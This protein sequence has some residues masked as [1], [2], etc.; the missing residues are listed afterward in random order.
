MQDG[1]E[2]FTWWENGVCHGSGC[3]VVPSP[4]PPPFP[5]PAPLAPPPPPT[6]PPPPYVP[7][8]YRGTCADVPDQNG[9]TVS[10][11]SIVPDGT[12]HLVAVAGCDTGYAYFC[13]DSQRWD[14]T[15][16]SLP[17]PP[18]C[19]ATRVNADYECDDPSQKP[20]VCLSD[21]ANRRSS[22]TCL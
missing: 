13:G 19:T 11:L 6:P 20:I 10:Y 3:P 8:Y 2:R 15:C 9:A 18:D 7:P 17:P 16:S 14:Y 1:T 5:P 22:L 12:G 4:P 21:S